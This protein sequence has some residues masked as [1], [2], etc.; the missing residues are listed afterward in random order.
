MSLRRYNS[1]RHGQLGFRL[2]TCS[3]RAPQNL[4]SSPALH[5]HA[6]SPRSS[7]AR[8]SVMMCPIRLHARARGS[9]RPSGISVRR[10]ISRMGGYYSRKN[11]HG[12]ADPSAAALAFIRVAMPTYR[13]ECG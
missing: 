4:P 2:C 13:S 6:P 1:P 9:R 5:L 12:K 10:R 8:S 11:A 7:S 3:T